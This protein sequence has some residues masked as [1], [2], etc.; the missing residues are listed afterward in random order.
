MA[1]AA[2]HGPTTGSGLMRCPQCKGSTTVID[3]REQT[4]GTTRRRKCKDCGTRFETRE[5]TEADHQ[6]LVD[7]R[8]D[9]RTLQRIIK[10]GY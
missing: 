1:T 5:L 3:S 2:S 10:K 9:L 8:T 6:S 7:I 4:T